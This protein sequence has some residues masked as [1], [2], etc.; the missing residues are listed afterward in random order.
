MQI[1]L[2]TQTHPD[3][4]QVLFLFTIQGAISWTSKRQSMVA[5]SSTESEYIGL[6]NDGQYLA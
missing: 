3:Q 5:L 6:S 4:H 1:D 2:E